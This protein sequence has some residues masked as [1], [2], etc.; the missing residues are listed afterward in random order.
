MNERLEH[1][2]HLGGPVFDGPA[3][4]FIESLLQKSEA[5]DGPAGERL[6]R[7][8]EARLDTFEQ[9]FHA[10]QTESA[11]IL[12]QLQGEG[13][14]PGDRFAEAFRTGDF[15]LLLRDGPRALRQ[16]RSGTAEAA[17][18]RIRR[19]LTE[20]TR[21][22][23]R[24]SDELAAAAEASLDEASRGDPRGEGTSRAVGDRL[25]QTLYRE[26]ASH[27]RAAVVVARAHDKLTDAFGPY[28]P[29]ALA[30]R[31]L[32]QIE[33]TSPAYL[34]SYLA[35]LEDLAALRQLPEQKR[36]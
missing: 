21:R 4:R 30:A 31:A 11:G 7:R 1:V 34:R 29:Q 15:G 22:G 13:A 18:E 28:N 33:A 24:L 26:A 19:L 12:A 36:R 6:R 10:A 9:A 17:R 35:A 14:D 8:A 32:A 23:V 3:F 2:R 5:M 25:A 20:V 16:L 27:V